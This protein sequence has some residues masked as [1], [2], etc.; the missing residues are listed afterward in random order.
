MAGFNKVDPVLQ[1]EKVHA[2]DFVYEMPDEQIAEHPANPRDNSRLLVLSQ[3][4]EAKE[5]A[6]F[7][8]IGSYLSEGDVLVVNN[9]KVH[10]AKFETIKEETGDDIDVFLLRELEPGVWEVQVSPPRKVRIGNTLRFADDLIADIIDNTVSS[11]R[12]IQ[13]Q[14]KDKDVADRLRK[15]GK[16]PL[17]PY[18]DRAAREID[19]EEYQTIFSEKV[20]SVA[21]PSGGLHFTESLVNTLKERGIV[22]VEITVHL[23]LGGYEKVTLSEINKYT[24]NADQFFIS[25]EAAEQINQALENDN[26]VIAVGASVVRALMSSHFQGKKIIPD[27]GWTDLFIYPPFH[28]NLLSGLITNFHR[29]QAPTLLLQSAFLGREKILDAYHYAMDHE[30]RFEAFGDAMLLLK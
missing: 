21:V 4:E 12:V 19:H 20:G 3:Q 23:G 15:I 29:P 22:F 13:F 26:K 17:P 8:E 2:V 10:P 28:F 5:E 11:G 9:T 6:R 30:Y 14:K 27:N 24:M 18:I 1:S 25:I 16:M 7:S